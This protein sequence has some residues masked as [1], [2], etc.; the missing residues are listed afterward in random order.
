VVH[1][2]LV[3]QKA[4]L[5]A[6]RLKEDEIADVDCNFIYEAAMLHDI[7]FKFPVGAK[8]RE[9]LSTC[10]V[11]HGY[12]GAEILR[13]E[14]LPLYAR[15][16]ERHVGMGILAKDIKENN[17]PI[18]EADYKPQT[19]EEKII[20]FADLFFSKKPEALF[21][22]GT[23]EQIEQEISTYSLRKEKL[24]LFRAWQKEFSFL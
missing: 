22:E 6:K 2:V 21:K 11:A 19:V 18:P 23:P 12:Y 4:L 8:N 5:I 7:G 9:E 15:V 17:W 13:K 24:A 16:A 3:A 10:Y 1:S 14:K 20:S